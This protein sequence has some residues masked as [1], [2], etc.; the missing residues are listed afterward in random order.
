MRI[1]IK[2][3]FNVFIILVGLSEICVIFMFCNFL[4]FLTHLVIS[5]QQF[6]PVFLSLLLSLL[7]PLP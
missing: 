1:G 5:P 2:G 6:S 7:L 4:M 3:T